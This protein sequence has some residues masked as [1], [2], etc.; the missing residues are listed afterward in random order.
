MQQSF[1]ADGYA[2]DWLNQT[3]WFASPCL[4]HVLMSVEQV[5]STGE[6]MH[7][8][9]YLASCQTGWP[10][11]I[12]QETTLGTLLKLFTTVCTIPTFEVHGLYTNLSIITS[13]KHFSHKNMLCSSPWVWNLCSLDERHY[14]WLVQQLC[15]TQQNILPMPF[16]RWCPVVPHSS[17]PPFLNRLTVVLSHWQDGIIQC[18]KLGERKG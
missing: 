9:Q 8:K 12:N 17:S 6:R 4:D 16:S 15:I 1:C 10:F 3:Q 13:Q 7:T 14:L 18:S 5:K 2:K 11:T